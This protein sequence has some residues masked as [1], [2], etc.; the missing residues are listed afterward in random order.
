MASPSASPVTVAPREQPSGRTRSQALA[1]AISGASAF[2]LGSLTAA[3]A[4]GGL[5]GPWLSLVSV[6]T[7]PQLLLWLGGIAVLAVLW[8]R[9]PAVPFATVAVVLAPIATVGE[10]L[11]R[12]QGAQLIAYP[13][14]IVV[15]AWQ[16]LGLIGA[17]SVGAIAGVLYRRD[18]EA[19]AARGFSAVDGPTAHLA[20]EEVE[21]PDAPEE[22]AENPASP[23]RGGVLAGVSITLLVIGSALAFVL[24]LQWFGVYFRLWGETAV[25]TPA[26]GAR[27]LWTAGLALAFLVA[28]LIVAI[29]RR[30]AGLVVLTMLAVACALVGAFVFQV[31]QGRF[32][33]EPAAPAYDV[34]FPV[35]YGTTGDCPGG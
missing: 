32:R 19:K 23:D 30:R 12:G 4:V 3:T 16:S 21:T 11:L 5:V 2:I 6:I 35:C 33:P 15:T 17:A 26:H 25:A 22:E 34:D 28:A 31:P 18:R 7:S 13:Y 1:T 20:D 10:V 9:G 29:V 8:R 14:L 27:Y 24:P